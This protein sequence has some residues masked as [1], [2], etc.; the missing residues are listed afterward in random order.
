[1][2]AG[3]RLLSGD[4]IELL[5]NEIGVHVASAGKIAELAIFGGSAIA[6]MFDFRNATRDVDYIPISGDMTCLADAISAISKKHA[7]TADWFNDAVEVFASGTPAYCLH[8]EYPIGNPGIRVFIASPEYILA[9]KIYSMRSSF[10]SNDVKDIW[11]LID[12]IGIKSCDDAIEIAT[13]FY[14]DKDVPERNRMI[15]MDLF[16]AKQKKVSYNPM[17]GWE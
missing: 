16:E 17:M 8:G 12:E 7:L 11:H 5:L 6:I 1:V 10:S 15:V 3:G 13:K 14:P 9:M 4:D 2:S